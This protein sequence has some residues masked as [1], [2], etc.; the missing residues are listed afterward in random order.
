MTWFEFDVDVLVTGRRSSVEVMESYGLLGSNVIL[1]HA[2]LLTTKEIALVRRRNAHISVS[3]SVELQMGMGT[4]ACFDRDRDVQSQCS[5][6]HDCHNLCVTSIPAEIRCALQSSR[7]VEND[8]FI[9][10]GKLPAKIYKTVQEAYALGT[11]Q[12]ARGIRMG[13]QIGSLAVGKLA[14]IIVLDALSPSMVCA[15]QYDPVAALVMHSTPGDIVMTIVDGV[16]RKREGK[17]EPVLVDAE[18]YPYTGSDVSFLQWSD[19]AEALLRSK[20]RI[21]KKVESIDFGAEKPIAMKAYG[22]DGSSMV[23]SV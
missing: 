9:A 15:S 6:G 1:S 23:D 17:L 5:I 11:V 12:A 2:N 3:P 14:D 7:G 16:V 20:D 21:Q 13:D 8:K 19:V 18:A 22:F 10:E 4:P